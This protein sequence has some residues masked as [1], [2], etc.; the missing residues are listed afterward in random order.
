[1]MTNEF[2]E[3]ED[4]KNRVMFVKWNNL[5]MFWIYVMFHLRF[6]EAGVFS[7]FLFEDV[8]SSFTFMSVI[9]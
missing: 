8:E 6:F 4:R 5:F 3:K 2:I 9:A 1:M 7:K